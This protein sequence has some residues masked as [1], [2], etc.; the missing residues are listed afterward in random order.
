VAETGKVRGPLCGSCNNGLG[1][2]KDSV[3]LLE[4]AIEY[5]EKIRE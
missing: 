1:R 4:R 2:F 5:L 3:K